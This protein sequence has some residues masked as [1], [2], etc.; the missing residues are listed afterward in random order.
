MGPHC[1]TGY[2]DLLALNLLMRYLTSS[3]VSPLQKNMSEIEDPFASNISCYTLEFLTPLLIFVFENAPIK[4]ID[5]ILEK[6][7][8]ILCQISNEE[9]KIDIERMHALIEKNFL[10]SLCNLEDSPHN[11]LEDQLVKNCIY[12]TNVDNDVSLFVFVF[13]YLYKCLNPVIRPTKGY[14]PDK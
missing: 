2:R 13:F 6:L 4:R 1:V 5:D 9:V 10:E 7:Q 14:N 8:E 3:S 12:G 11:A